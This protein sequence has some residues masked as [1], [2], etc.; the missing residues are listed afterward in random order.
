MTGELRDRLSHKELTA[1]I[2][3]RIKAAGI[4]RVGVRMLTITGEQAIAVDPLGG[5]DARFTY[6]EQRT[7][8]LIAQ[9]NHLTYVRGLP[10]E[11]DAPDVNGSGFWFYLGYA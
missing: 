9:V 10:I 7:I 8:R 3:D 5:V 2:R 11:V 6:E 4:K 1:H